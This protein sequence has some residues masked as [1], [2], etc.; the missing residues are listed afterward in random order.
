MAKG[1]TNKQKAFINEY[2]IG[3]FNGTDAARRAGYKGNDATLASIAY[4][5]LRKPQI[6]EEIERRMKESAMGAAEVLYRLT[7]HARGD[8]GEFIAV[9]YL[10]LQSHPKSRL[11]KKIKRTFRVDKDES[12]TEH[13][14]LELYDAQAALVQL[15]RSHALFT[16]K[17]EHSGTLHWGDIV[18]GD[19]SDDHEAGETF[20]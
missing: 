18:K 10:A 16:D 13:I 17:Q 5:N 20:A 4:E 11:V 7:E 19:L 14:E 12:T 1:L 6:K 15:G 2:F 8:I 3:G 9:D